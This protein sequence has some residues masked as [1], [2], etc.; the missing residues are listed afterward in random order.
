MNKSYKSLCVVV[1]A[2]ALVGCW[3]KKKPSSS[4][5]EY[6]AAN[7]P[8]ADKNLSVVYFDYDSSAIRGDQTS[9][10]NGNAAVLKNMGKS[11][12]I[13]GHCDDRGST[14][15]NMALG[16]RRA[17]ATKDYLVNMGVDPALLR[18]VSFGEEKP[19][20]VCADESC[21]SMNRRAEFVR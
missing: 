10:I 4:G 8:K 19:A 21:W 18:T 14:D 1:L 15:Y 5:G 6:S 16:E 9:R 13:E 20:S 12:I 17:R 3:G 11:V 2:L 7:P